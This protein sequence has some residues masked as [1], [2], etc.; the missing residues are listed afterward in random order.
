MSA[1]RADETAPAGALAR[2][3]TLIEV[4]AA[5]TILVMVALVVIP[6]LSLR[7][8]Q[9]ALDEGKEL[10]ALIELARSTAIVSGVPQRVVLDLDGGAYWAEGGPSA[11]PA[12]EPIAWS[13]VDPLPLVAPRAEAA[14][15][16]PL[17]GPLGRPTRLRNEVRFGGVETDSGA[18]AEGAIA[19]AFG[20]DGVTEPARI[21]LI[22]SDETAVA[23]EV[24]P[25]ADVTRV[26][27][28]AA[29]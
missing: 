24:A 27:F 12:P 21:W 1:A 7:A 19:I 22:A 8:S 2:G 25:L 11:A 28:V 10:G 14:A 18:L 17:A 3:F 4:L 6:R 23:L 26:G 9:A 29:R 15:F 13:A 16:A 5:V 20:S